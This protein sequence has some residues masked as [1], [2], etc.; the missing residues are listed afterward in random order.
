MTRSLA[1]A[2]LSRAA[3]VAPTVIG[4]LLRA[5]NV[6]DAAEQVLAGKIAAEVPRD[7]R[8]LAACDLERAEAIGARLLPREGAD[9][10]GFPLWDLD[11]PKV[12][13]AGPVA[14]WVRGAARINPLAQTHV[15]VVGARAATE[16]G[17]A[18]TTEI[19][20]GL[21]E[22]GWTVI[23][24]GGYGVEEAAHRAALARDG[25]T[26]AVLATGLGRTCPPAQ[27]ALFD[28]IAEKG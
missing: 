14:L 26:I 8:G 12:R 3:L 6:W 10:P 25:K 11:A 23:S 4:D 17:V 15:A 21:T 13:S 22:R 16:R 5:Q 19:T 7:L 1:W 2:I 18:V 28:G 27:Q 20:D 9:W 24:G